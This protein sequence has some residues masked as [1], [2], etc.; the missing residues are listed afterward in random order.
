LSDLAFFLSMRFRAAPCQF[1]CL[2]MIIQL[3]Y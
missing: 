3:V 2:A 1:L